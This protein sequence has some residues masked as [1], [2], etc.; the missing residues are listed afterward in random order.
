MC[1]SFSTFI[2]FPCLLCSHVT[3]TKCHRMVARIF[4][5][6]SELFC[7][8][9]AHIFCSIPLN[10]ILRYSRV[11]RQQSASRSVLNCI[12][13]LFIVKSITFY[14][15]CKTCFRWDEK[16]F[17]HLQTVTNAK[18]EYFH[19]NGDR[20]F[21]INSFLYWKNASSD[22]ILP[23]AVHKSSDKVH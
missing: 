20:M 1:E 10:A 23:G 11:L 14:L 8:Y 19:D 22:E 13:A 15:V 2:P 12:K 9:T 21:W 16:Y 5:F 3:S 4:N 17:I 18:R 7:H 6:W